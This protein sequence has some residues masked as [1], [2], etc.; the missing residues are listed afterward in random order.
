[1]ARRPHP[2]FYVVSAIAIVAAVVAVATEAREP[3]WALRSAWIYRAEI[4]A[5]LLGLIYIPMVAL[6]LAWDGETFRRFR[7]PAGTGVEAP[8]DEIDTAAKEFARYRKENDGR[9]DAIEAAVDKLNQRVD[10]FE[11]AEKRHP[12]DH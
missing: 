12:N 11:T 8:A 5:S 7:G 4:F 10:A 1:M 3:V 9:L 6:Y 2:L